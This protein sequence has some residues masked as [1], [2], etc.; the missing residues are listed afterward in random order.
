MSSKESNVPFFNLLGE[1]ETREAA[2]K[3]LASKINEGE[4]ILDLA[5]GSGYLVRNLLDK[6]AFIVCLDFDA[7]PLKKTKNELSNVKYVRADALHLPFKK[8][9]FDRVISWSA[10]VHIENWRGVIGEAFRVSDKMLTAE[11]Q[12]DFQVRAFR[13]FECKHTYPNKKEL[14]AEFEKHGRA[15][16]EQINFISI[17]NCKN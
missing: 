17:I 13:D 7:K 10:L 8:S 2:L 1:L 16:I 3:K 14:Q 4:S 15:N 6:N 12:G 11:P 5:T 9:S